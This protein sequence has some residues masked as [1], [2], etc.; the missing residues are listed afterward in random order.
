MRI[1]SIIAAT[2][3]CALGAGTASAVQTGFNQASGVFQA[4]Q[5]KVLSVDCPSGFFASGGGYSIADALQPVRFVSNITA[6]GVGSNIAWSFGQVNVPN[7]VVSLNQPTTGNGDGW[8]VGGVS[9]HDTNV[10]VY[11]MCV[12]RG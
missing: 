11:V 10:T 2:A 8:A 4:G 1:V 12:A 7:L 6:T 3:I 9:N 5:A